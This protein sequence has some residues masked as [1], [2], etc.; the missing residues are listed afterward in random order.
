MG[1]CVCVWEEEGV[2]G[3]GRGGLKGQAITMQVRIWTVIYN[4]C[5]CTSINLYLQQSCGLLFFN[6]L[7]NGHVKGVA[8]VPFLFLLTPPTVR[9]LKGI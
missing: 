8:V 6:V 5:L 2:G 1:V 4:L 9:Y 7:H 3:G